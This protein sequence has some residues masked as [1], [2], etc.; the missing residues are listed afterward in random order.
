MKKLAVIFAIAALYTA[1]ASARVI[2]HESSSSGDIVL[3]DIAD[4]CKQGFNAYA[5]L[6]AKGKIT[7]TGCWHFFNEQKFILFEDDMNHAVSLIEASHF[8]LVQPY[9]PAT[10]TSNRRA[11]TP[12]QSGAL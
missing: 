7:N 5:V 9:D 2:A 10:D 3:T 11:N 8:S 1:N 4:T 6:D 12:K